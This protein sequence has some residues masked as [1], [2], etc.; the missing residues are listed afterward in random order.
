[1][2]SHLR[3]TKHRDQKL[4]PVIHTLLFAGYRNPAQAD[5]AKEGVWIKELV[6]PRSVKARSDASQV[7]P[8]MAQ[9]AA[10]HLP[11]LKDTKFQL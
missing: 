6:T 11:F 10:H 1:M 2:L 4:V 3:N 7:S 5:L 8:C 9:L